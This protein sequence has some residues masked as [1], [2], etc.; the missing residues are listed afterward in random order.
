MKM[1][2][3]RDKRGLHER[4]WIPLFKTLAYIFFFLIVAYFL[5]SE[6]GPWLLQKLA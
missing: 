1:K 3:I 2:I 4:N 5:V 6:L